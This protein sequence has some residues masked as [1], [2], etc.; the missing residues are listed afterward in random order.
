MFIYNIASLSIY[1]DSE[2]L[3]TTVLFLILGVILASAYT[4]FIKKFRGEFVLAL[5]ESEAFD[6][7]SAKSLSELGIKNSFFRKI[8][9]ET[10]FFF[11]PDYFEVIS[12][13]S[14]DKENVKYYV[15]E[16]AADRLKSKYGNSEITFIQLLITLIAILAVALVLA[17]AV[18]DILSM[19]NL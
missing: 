14:K 8:S 7:K 9:I 1:S 17:T 18:P 19:F 12:S 16:E 13:K 6:E 15:N 11:S 4:A 10:K 5:I 2:K 3:G